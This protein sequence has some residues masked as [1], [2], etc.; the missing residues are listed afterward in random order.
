MEENKKELNGNQNYGNDQVYGQRGNHDQSAYEQQT[1]VQQE[2][3]QQGNGW[4]NTENG[5]TN[6]QQ[7]S[8][9]QMYGQTYG[10]QNLNQQTYEQ[11][12]GQQNHNQQTYGQQYYNQPNYAHNSYP[13]ER[14]PVTDVFCYLLLVIFPL[15]YIF[16]FFS[17]NTVFSNMDYYNIMYGSYPSVSVGNAL[18]SVISYL[19]T[20]GMI[21]FFVMDIVKIHKQNYNILGLILFAIFLKPG[22]YLWRAHILGRKK[23]IP[24]IYTVLLAL[25]ILVYVIYVMYK[26]FEMVGMIMMMY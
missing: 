12:Y 24:I 16:G 10:Q 18:I 1:N 2:N 5:Q 23:T 20:I 11:I 26:T 7:N 17:V 4:Q 3:N 19:L 13:C 15:R 22:Y 14:G 25:L 21:A 6:V 9:Q 8:N